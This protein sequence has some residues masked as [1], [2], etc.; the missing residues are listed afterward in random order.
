[1]SLLDD[2]E[3][4]IK[5]GNPNAQTV[6]ACLAQLGTPTVSIAVLED[7]S[8]SSR[9]YST[10][11]DDA[12]TIF[13]ACSIS[14][15][16]AAM[17][18]MRLV[19]Q[20]RLALDGTIGSLLPQDVVNM[21]TEGCPP[22]QTKIIEGITI[23]QLMSHTSGLSQGGFPGYAKGPIPSARDILKGAYPVNTMRVRLRSLPGH[24]FSY[25]GGGITV[26]QVILETVTG[27]DFPSLI[28]DLVLEP[29]D[30]KRSFYGDLPD[31][32]ANAARAHF[33]GYTPCDS[34]NH[35]LPELAA[36]GLWT[37][38]TDLLKVV[39]AMQKSLVGDAFLRQETAKEMLTLVDNE[40]A[41]SWFPS[42]TKAGFTHAGANDPG[43]RCILAGYAD[44]GSDENVP[45]NCGYAIMTNS[46][47]GN[48]AYMKVAQ[49]ICYLKTWPVFKCAGSDMVLAPFPAV[50]ASVGDGWK[51]WIGTWSD[52]KHT[53][54][55]DDED[56]K[57]VF[58]T[59][60][61]FAVNMLPAAMPLTEKQEQEGQQV[62]VLEGFEM[63]ICLKTDDGQRVI[64][65][66][67]FISGESLTLKPKTTK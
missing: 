34:T 37:T 57:P 28:R 2:L 60:G 52:D 58:S 10:V 33:T 29:L 62:F 41:L 12:E 43:Y 51:P 19:D 55:L 53:C 17:A 65:F 40:M 25:S 32:E 18:I 36:A 64:V 5:G 15:P 23:K 35:V 61:S 13:Q 11:G 6:A 22:A 54:L 39:V 48:E 46:A 9:C 63:V 26:L 1:M 44:L 45:E 27:K 30:M 47:C 8:V 20:G 24:S 49:A 4:L 42:K 66:G 21:L 3:A 59:S 31:G 38:P 16:V 14:K 56:G 67:S 50:N 7:G